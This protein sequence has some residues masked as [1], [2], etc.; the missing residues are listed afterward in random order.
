MDC[1]ALIILENIAVTAALNVGDS[2][3]IGDRDSNE[4]DY[5]VVVEVLSAREVRVR[6]RIG[7][8]TDHENPADLRP[9]PD[10]QH[11]Y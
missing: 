1:A 6:W 5:G 3:E 8:F 11:S 7:G 9:R 2:V 10:G 4:Y